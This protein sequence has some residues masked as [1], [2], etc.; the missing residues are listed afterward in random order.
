MKVPYVLLWDW[1]IRK[2]Q[3][4]P[5]SAEVGLRVK[6]AGKSQRATSGLIIKVP[7]SS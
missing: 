1:Q 3:K 5:S 7:F 6:G 2:L 4:D